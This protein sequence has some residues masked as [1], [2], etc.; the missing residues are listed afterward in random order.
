MLK[1]VAP[2][3]AEN[4]CTEDALSEIVVQGKSLGPRFLVEHNLVHVVLTDDAR[5]RRHQVVGSI[6]NHFVAQRRLCVVHQLPQI[7]EGL[8]HLQHFLLQR[9]RIC[10]LHPAHLTE[11]NDLLE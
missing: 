8:E 11:F 10:M 7:V 3:D 5:R 4:A 9:S 1:P 2:Q 6:K